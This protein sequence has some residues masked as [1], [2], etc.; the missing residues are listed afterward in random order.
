MRTKRRAAFHLYQAI[1]G[2]ALALGALLSSFGV[3]AAGEDHRDS[4]YVLSNTTDDNAVLIFR[5]AADGT[6]APAGSKRTGGRGNGGSLGSQGAIVLSENGRWL[7][8]VNAGSNDISVFEVRGDDLDRTDRVA[9][10][11]EQPI[12]L[13]VHDD[14]VYV[15]NAGGSGNISGFRLNNQGKLASLAGST[16]ALSN[17]GVGPAPGP[18]QVQFS[19]DGG[20]LVVTEKATN[21]IDTFRVKNNGIAA[22]AVTHPSAG[23][24]PFGF[25]IDK[26]NHVLV[27]EAAGGP[28]G[29]SALSSYALDHNQLDT[30]SPS[31]PTQQNAACWV[32]VTKN[33]RYVYTANAASNSISGY[34][35]GHD[36]QLTLLASVAGATDD[37]P[38]DM[39][40]SRDNNIL[41]VLNSFAHNIGAF[42]VRSDGSLTSL[43]TFGILPASAVGMA[44]S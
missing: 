11:G 8:A 15:L 44:A 22:P 4:V 34:R 35:V 1:V 29:S 12:S 7:F 20:T 6:L 26:R 28:A 14:L 5:R 18:A 31:V 43:G 30:I 39:D 13:T 21:L 3:A 37:H 10:G 19:D 17:G 23:A 9:S 2:L 41:Y 42:R 38:I 25:A 16:R 27:S 24:T 36:G 32:V 40:L 33:G